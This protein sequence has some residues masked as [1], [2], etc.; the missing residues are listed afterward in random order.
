MRQKHWTLPLVA[1]TGLCLGAATHGADTPPDAASVVGVVTGLSGPGLV[2][3]YASGTRQAIDANGE[4]HSAD[5]HAED[6]ATGITIFAQPEGARCTVSNAPGNSTAGHAVSVR[7]DCIPVH[8]LGGSVAGLTGQGLRLRR[9]DGESLAIAA[10]G[11]FT[12]PGALPADRA[13]EVTIEAQPNQSVCEVSRGVGRIG[14]GDVSDVAVTCRTNA[15]GFAYV[16]N[17]AAKNIA[18][19]RIDAGSGKLTAA[20]NPVP[21]GKDPLSLTIDPL[22]RFAYVANYGSN[23]ILVYRIDR[24]TGTNRRVSVLDQI[25]RASCREKL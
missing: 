21:A 19:F 20:G 3:Q 14:V 22:G 12:F 23:N 24:A 6:G 13:Y 4:F 2:L 8:R 16:L 18:I 7:V 1:A 15:S 25:G 17:T 9:D 11:S 5:T 10:D